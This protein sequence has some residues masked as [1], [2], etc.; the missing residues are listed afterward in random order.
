MTNYD[1]MMFSR[2]VVDFSNPDFCKKC[3]R[4]LG[5][6]LTDIALDENQYACRFESHN[7]CELE[8]NGQKI[9]ED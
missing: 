9:N 8:N 2:E 1:E 7:G 6:H 5:D 3:G 4:R